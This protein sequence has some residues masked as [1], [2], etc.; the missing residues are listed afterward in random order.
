MKKS[1]I[2]LYHATC[3]DGFTAAW[4]AWKKF[5]AHATYFPVKHQVPP[6]KGVEGKEVFLLDFSYNAARIQRLAAENT[7]VTVL[8]HH[9]SARDDLRA[10][11]ERMGARTRKAHATS[12]NLSLIYDV[13]H[14]GAFLAWRY[15]HPKKPVP[16]I[17]RYVEDN[18]L[19]Q[20]RLPHTRELSLFLDAHE[21]AFP[22]WEKLASLFEKRKTRQACIEKGKY[23]ARFADG[24]V[25]DV[26]SSA[27]KVNFAGEVVLAANSPVLRSEI[28]HELV[29][30]RPPFSIVWREKGGQIA[31]SLR[32]DG[33]FDVAKLAEKYG[34]GGH[35][36]AAGFTLKQGEKIPWKVR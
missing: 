33:T 8:D 2:V 14:S 30:K 35:K 15:F 3:P 26:S 19:W 10:L 11:F 13:A 16:Q 7:R 34:G 24:I 4:A 22:V 20:F 12:A 31:V 32:S 21:C 1:T 6:P 28:G 36:S 17:V 27:C 23:I 5:R 9:V 29:K 25:K 18:D